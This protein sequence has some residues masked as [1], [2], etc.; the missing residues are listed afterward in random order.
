MRRAVVG[1]G[2]VFVAASAVG[3]AAQPPIPAKAPAPARVP[4]LSADPAAERARLQGQI[5]E[6]I[7]QLKDRPTGPAAKTKASGPKLELPPG[8]RPVDRLRS[9]VNLFK[10]G[11]TDAALGAFRQLD[12][13]DLPRED[14]ATAKYL[15]ACCLR[16]LNRRS[17]AAVLFR[18]VAETKDDDFLAECAISQL[19]LIRTTQDLE[20]LLTQFRARPKSP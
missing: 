6:L 16:K 19:A 8:T 12:P 7:R 5:L 14:R 4:D 20:A 2:L 10:A 9:A 17:E 1:A 11:D 13:D 15:T 3:A 18:E